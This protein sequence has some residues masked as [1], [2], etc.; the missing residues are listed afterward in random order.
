MTSPLPSHRDVV[1]AFVRSCGQFERL[2]AEMPTPS[3]AAELAI[4]AVSHFVSHIA[5]PLGANRSKFETLVQDIERETQVMM[6]AIADPPAAPGVTLPE[7]KASASAT[8]LAILQQKL[9]D[10]IRS[11]EHRAAFPTEAARNQDTIH[12]TALL[13]RETADKASTRLDIGQW[14]RSGDLAEVFRTVTDEFSRISEARVGRATP[15]QRAP[16]ALAVVPEKQSKLSEKKIERN[17]RFLAALVERESRPSLGR[18]RR[19][20]LAT[21]VQAA[22]LFESAIVALGASSTVLKIGGAIVALT[23]AGAFVYTITD[24]KAAQAQLLN[25]RLWAQVQAQNSAWETV[26]EWFQE[27]FADVQV[28]VARERQK[29]IRLVQLWVAEVKEAADDATA[30]RYIETFYESFIKMLETDASEERTLF[31]FGLQDA[32]K[33]LDTARPRIAIFASDSSSGSAEVAFNAKETAKILIEEFVAFCEELLVETATQRVAETYASVP[34]DQQAALLRTFARRAGALTTDPRTSAIVARI[35][36]VTDNKTAIAIRPNDTAIGASVEEAYRQLTTQ[37]TQE[38][39]QQSKSVVNVSGESLDA[40][41]TLQDDVNGTQTITSI[42]VT[43]A[44]DQN[45]VP[46]PNGPGLPKEVAFVS[47]PESSSDAPIAMLPSTA[48]LVER[49]KNDGRLQISK[50]FYAAP[51]SPDFAED[52]FDVSVDRNPFANGLNSDSPPELVVAYFRAPSE[53]VTDDQKL[54]YLPHLRAFAGAIGVLQRQSGVTAQ[55]FVEEKTF[56]SLLDERFKRLADIKFGVKE[57]ATRFAAQGLSIDQ[58]KMLASVPTKDNELRQLALHYI[59]AFVIVEAEVG[60]NDEYD[61]SRILGNQQQREK[62]LAANQQPFV[63]D[64][65]EQFGM[66]QVVSELWGSRLMKGFLLAQRAVESGPGRAAGTAERRF[67]YAVKV[68]DAN[69]AGVLRGSV[70]RERWFNASSIS[71]AFNA[72]QLMTVTIVNGLSTDLINRLPSPFRLDDDVVRR[73]EHVNAFRDTVMCDPNLPL[74]RCPY[75]MVDR[76]SYETMARADST[77]KEFVLA[78]ADSVAHVR[79]FDIKNQRYG[80]LLAS[81]VLPTLRNI[82]VSH[83]FDQTTQTRAIQARLDSLMNPTFTSDVPVEPSGA[84][85]NSFLGPSASVLNALTSA[86]SYWSSGVDEQRTFAIGFAGITALSYWAEMAVRLGNLLFATFPGVKTALIKALDYLRL[87][88]ERF[89]LAKLIGVMQ[90]FKNKLDKEGTEYWRKLMAFLEPLLA[91][92]EPP[93]KKQPEPELARKAKTKKAK[94]KDVQIVTD[95][96]MAAAAGVTANRFLNF[97]ENAFDWIIASIKGAPR[98]ALT[99]LRTTIRGTLRA[100][101]QIPWLCSTVVAKTAAAMQ[102]NVGDTLQKILWGATGILLVAVL[103]TLVTNAD[104]F[105]TSLLTRTLSQFVLR[106]TMAM[107]KPAFDR[108]FVASSEIPTE[109]ATARLA[110]IR[111]IREGL[112]LVGVAGLTLAPWLVSPYSTIAAVNPQGAIASA[113]TTATSFFEP[114]ADQLPGSEAQVAVFAGKTVARLFGAHLFSLYGQSDTLDPIEEARAR[115]ATILAFSDRLIGELAKRG[116]EIA[117]LV[118]DSTAFRISIVWQTIATA[119]IVVKN[120]ALE[121]YKKEVAGQLQLVANNFIILIAEAAAD[122]PG[123]LVKL[124]ATQK[125]KVRD[126][127]LTPELLDTIMQ[128]HVWSGA[129]EQRKLR[130]VATLSRDVAALDILALEALEARTARESERKKEEEEEELESGFE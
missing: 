10:L 125:T 115:R 63:L 124:T 20:P 67:E 45:G 93:T 40:A 92:P 76:V 86:R 15:R 46:T 71:P 19:M 39:A 129:D 123:T 33:A 104:I 107:I 88:A 126:S 54:T 59:N 103:P 3:D 95:S 121:P 110:R 43:I 7:T 41:G 47:P 89:G 13:S 18:L 101:E 74:E 118:D 127:K 23:G 12:L 102:Q 50:K 90:D 31:S 48:F 62:Y 108:A 106:K 78:D 128:N 29:R 83:P 66:D 37:T 2:A 17:R 96:A 52:L 16:S 87:Q 11:A 5:L 36:L 21:T 22:V 130:L 1:D 81:V 56:A 84:W 38:S 25:D 24:R 99:S 8:R 4:D 65:G 69:E 34:S 94:G 14:A 35:A 100:I 26:K 105:L 111:A 119:A 28:I 75:T 79:I 27:Y 97:V 113:I 77:G 30:L 114:A 64:N 120:G 80:A 73:I 9:S 116:T 70:V 122:K 82:A 55:G 42:A 117:S 58:P 60:L 44:R 72:D 51:P 32:R 91:D 49:A 109:A 98:N 112:L 53:I 68:A 57:L 85:F 6:R 61:F